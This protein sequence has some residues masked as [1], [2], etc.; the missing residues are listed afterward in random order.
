MIFLSLSKAKYPVF[1]CFR[2]SDP[3]CIRNI[4]FSQCYHY[5][6]DTQV[7]YC[8]RHQFKIGGYTK[9]VLVEY[10]SWIFYT[11]FK[12]G[13]PIKFGPLV[14]STGTDYQVIQFFFIQL[15]G[16]GLKD[17]PPLISRGN[18]WRQ[19]WHALA[20]HI[21]RQSPIFSLVTNTQLS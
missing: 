7:Y 19:D 16:F 6:N 15:S 5:K 8:T 9:F 10:K 20:E 12:F 11:Y 2:F 1:E 17:P 3:H 13:L 4:Q 18:T 21:D 14:W